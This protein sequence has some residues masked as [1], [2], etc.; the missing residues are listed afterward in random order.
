MWCFVIWKRGWVAVATYKNR[1]HLWPTHKALTSSIRVPSM[2][3]PPV[4][5]AQHSCKTEKGNSTPIS[6]YAKISH[7]STIA[8]CERGPYLETIREMAEANATM[9]SVEVWFHICSD[10][11]GSTCSPPTYSN[12]FALQPIS[13]IIFISFSLPIK[14]QPQAS[15]SSNANRRFTYILIRKRPTWAPS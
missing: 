13:F 6:R 9:A 12:K 15:K 10:A 11:A 2:Q 7:S 14:Q 4:S 5:T 1:F 3:I 8:V